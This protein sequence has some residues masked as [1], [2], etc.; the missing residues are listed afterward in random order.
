[1]RNK[2]TITDKGEREREINVEKYERDEQN[3]GKIF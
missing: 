1:M 3:S 2:G